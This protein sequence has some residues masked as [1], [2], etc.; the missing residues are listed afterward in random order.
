MSD[1]SNINN[2]LVKFPNIIKESERNQLA[3]EWR[4]FKLNDDFNSELPPVT[5]WSCLC[6][7]RNA[8]NIPVFPLISKVVKYVLSFPFGT[9]GVE[10]D[11]SLLSIIHSKLR[12]RLQVNTVDCLLRIRENVPEKFSDF[13]PSEKMFTL[14]NSKMCKNLKDCK[15]D[16]IEFC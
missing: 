1:Y 11:F 6:N 5:F 8:L 2:I 12:N 13:E 3:V 9:A 7:H 16:E 15:Y 14:F 10:R 4:M